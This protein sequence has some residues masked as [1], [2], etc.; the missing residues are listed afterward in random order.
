MFAGSPRQGKPLVRA[1]A[2]A[3]QDFDLKTILED[4][5]KAPVKGSDA[6]APAPLVSPVS[7]AVP[8][9]PSL[10]PQAIHLRSGLWLS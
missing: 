2:V 10:P 7:P 8:E 4:S 9:A 6:A 3:D 1:A 5:L